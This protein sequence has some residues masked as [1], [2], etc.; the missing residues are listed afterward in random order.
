MKDK[1]KRDFLNTLKVLGDSTRLDIVLFL[2]SEEKCVCE[3][4]KHLHLPQNLI[5]HH[6]KVLKDNEILINHKEGKWVHY[7]INKENFDKIQRNLS[8]FFE[9]KKYYQNVK[10]CNEK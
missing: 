9:T 8:K 10:S 3:I 5:S 6:L 4:F 1:D 7:S 2:A